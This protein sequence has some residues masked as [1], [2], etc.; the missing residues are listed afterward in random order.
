MLLGLEQIKKGSRLLIGLSGG[1]DSMS[2]FH[3]LLDV[4]E[5]YGF[6]LYAVYIDHNLRKE[7][8][9]ES[10]A[11]A[12]LCKANGV[13][14]ESHS[15]DV[16]S[17][18][19]A[20]K[21]SL[22]A[23][24]HSLRFEVFNHL[25]KKAAIDYLVLGHTADDRAESFLMNLLYGAGLNGLSPLPLFEGKIWRP[26][27]ECSKEHLFFYAKEKGFDYF[28]DASNDS[29]IYFRNQIRHEVIPFLERYE[30]KLKEKLA[31]TAKRL[32]ESKMALLSVAEAYLVEHLKKEKMGYALKKEG[33]LS[34]P[35]GLQKEV[36]RVLLMRYLPESR[37]LN[38]V[39]WQ[40]LIQIL[41]QH[42]TKRVHIKGNWWFESTKEW[43][44]L[45]EMATLAPVP[46]LEKKPWEE[47]VVLPL[48]HLSK[49]AQDTG[50]ATCVFFSE[51][52]FIRFKKAGDKVFIK[53]LGHKTLKKIFQE[54]G[55]SAE[56][57][58]LWPI[59]VDENDHILWIPE[60]YKKE[61]NQAIIKP[62]LVLEWSLDDQKEE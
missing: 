30:P 48:G 22:E 51:A 54:K 44:F 40:T 12:K 15:I 57:R 50:L 42:E 56:K 11:L 58:K 55:I 62:S 47:T 24:G 41:P 38:E 28:H 3:A 9:D 2:L 19:K 29:L 31:G 8:K 18:A 5:R 7:S 27:I 46:W 20:N 26:L 13:F 21:E 32:Y 52:I 25:I 10:L 53:G 17:Y 59:V 49:T 37:G 61:E 45:K 34:L 33:L 35:L 36:L 16:L 23:S 60:L 6:T 4:R 39:R 43:L 14:Y 1:V